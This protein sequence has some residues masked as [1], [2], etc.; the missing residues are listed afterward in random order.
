M[1]FRS[2]PKSSALFQPREGALYDPP[3]GDDGEG[4]E[5]V[6][7]GDLDGCVE[8]VLDR[9]GERFTRVAAIDQ[10]AWQLLCPHVGVHGVV[11]VRTE[12]TPP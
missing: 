1:I 10:H 12:Q 2:F 8:L 7:F 3:L 9:I 5:L 11:L 4:V 6:A